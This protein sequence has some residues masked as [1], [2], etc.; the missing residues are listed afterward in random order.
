ML[1]CL[2]ESLEY[3]LI[4]QCLSEEMRNGE[5]DIVYH[6]VFFL[7]GVHSFQWMY[8]C[9]LND[10]GTKGGYLQYGYDGDDFISFDKSSLTWTAANDKAVITKNKWDAIRAQS[11]RY[12][13]YLENECIEWIKKYVGY[14]KS[15]LE[16]KGMN[17]S[18]FDSHC[19]LIDLLFFR[20]KYPSE[21][22]IIHTSHLYFLYRVQC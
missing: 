19:I 1:S 15:T 9:E 17:I 5:F 20:N 14:G 8:G 11:E 7:S 3:V 18:C 4:N 10:D 2:C 21:C 16:R 6:V 22:P 13:E 12:K